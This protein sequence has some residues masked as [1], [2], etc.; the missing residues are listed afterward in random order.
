MTELL[1]EDFPEA[2]IRQCSAPGPVDDAVDYWLGEIGLALDPDEARRCL[3]GYGAWDED[4]LA[5]DAENRARIL[6][7]ACGYFNDGEDFYYMD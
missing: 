6:W 4:E 1:R 2:C 5:D 3:A 7:L